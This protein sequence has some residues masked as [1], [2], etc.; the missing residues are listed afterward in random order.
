MEKYTLDRFDED[1]AVL[2]KYPTEDEQLLIPKENLR[3]FHEGDIMLVKQEGEEF[4]FLPLKTETD[5]M[6]SKV[7]N[8]INKLK[9][10]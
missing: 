7:N 1:Y 4:S 8:L 10:K 2:L 5:A 9:T 3:E 6:K